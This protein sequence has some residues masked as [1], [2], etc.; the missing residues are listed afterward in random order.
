MSHF[1]FRSM[2]RWNS[3]TTGQKKRFACEHC[4]K[5]FSTKYRYAF[6]IRNLHSE[7]PPKETVCSMCNKRF[8]TR[9]AMN[10]RVTTIH[11]A[12]KY[13]CPTYSKNFVF[14]FFLF[15]LLYVP[16]QQLWSLRDGQ[17]A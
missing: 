1:I 11:M 17:F 15:L 12:E 9:S 16:C 14:F 10:N 2:E 8:S 3:Q 6:H 13:S 4:N 7:E 5:K